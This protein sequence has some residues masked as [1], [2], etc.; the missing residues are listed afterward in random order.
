MTGKAV[1]ELY[2]RARVFS[3]LPL[4]QASMLIQQ[5]KDIGASSLKVKKDSNTT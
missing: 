5:L 1:A 4:S 3:P 2:G